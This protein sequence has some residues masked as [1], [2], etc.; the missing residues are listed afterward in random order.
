MGDSRRFEETVKFIQR[1]YKQSLNILDVAG[2][3]GTLSVLL[4]RAGYSTTIVDP[5]I[6]LSQKDKLRYNIK[7]IKSKFNFEF[8][9][10]DYD[11][12]VGLHPDGATEHIIKAAVIQSKPFIVI[13]CC[14]IPQFTK[15]KYDF[16]TWIKYLRSMSSRI[17]ECQLPMTGK[18]IVLYSR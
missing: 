11:L 6:L 13:P 7:T 4:S 17:L 9:I 10:S 1:N 3:G 14:I 12:I 16:N 8:D 15:M 5:H 2:G 18:N